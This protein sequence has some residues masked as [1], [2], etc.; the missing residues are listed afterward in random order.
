MGFYP[1]APSSNI[2][3]I[4]SPGLEAVEMTLGNGKKISVTTENYTP[5]N[6]YIQEMYLNRNRYN[7]TYL[8]YE[9]I[10]NGADI[11]F[12]LGSQPNTSWGVSDESVAP[13]L[14]NPHQTLL[15]G[16]NR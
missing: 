16:K 2:Y 12:V 9:D 8:T 1:T 5:E 11:K 4:G 14:S 7:K 13:S 15:Y 10:R 6:V 3:S